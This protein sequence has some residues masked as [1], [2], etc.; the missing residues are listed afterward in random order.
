MPYILRR[1]T[2]GSKLLA[3][4]ETGNASFPF[5]T[6]DWSLSTGAAVSIVDGKLRVTGDGTNWG[7]VRRTGIA[8]RSKS[9][10][11]VV[12]RDITASAWLVAAVHLSDTADGY[13]DCVGS[14]LTTREGANDRTSILTST[15]GAV[16]HLPAADTVGARS[17]N[18][19][20]RHSMFADGTAVTQ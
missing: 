1:S 10:V 3:R 5:A 18:T 8:D 12:Q 15:D 11:Y 17:A 4:H 9:F 14:G 20:Y 19:D 16:G 7:F 6:G 13:N 2:A